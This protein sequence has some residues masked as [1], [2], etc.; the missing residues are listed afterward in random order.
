MYVFVL[1]AHYKER[2][3]DQQAMYIGLR[4]PEDR[5]K[6][7]RR[8]QSRSGKGA[9]FDEQ[10]GQGAKASEPGKIYSASSFCTKTN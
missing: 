4:Y 3:E 10:D 2:W 8:K 6:R 1:E 9:S 5:K 7:K